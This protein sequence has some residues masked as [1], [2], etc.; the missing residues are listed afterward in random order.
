MSGSYVF[1]CVGYFNGFDGSFLFPTIGVG[2]LLFID[3]HFIH[4]VSVGT[5]W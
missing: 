1:L 2:M 5:H 3:E 4:V